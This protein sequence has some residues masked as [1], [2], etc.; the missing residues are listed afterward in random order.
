MAPLTAVQTYGMIASAIQLGFH[1][2]SG[3]LIRVFGSR[4]NPEASVALV[5]P[6]SPFSHV[7]FSACACFF[8]LWTCQLSI[9]GPSSFSCFATIA[10]LFPWHAPH[11]DAFNWH[12][13]QP[14]STLCHASFSN[15]HRWST[16]YIYLYS[17][18]FIHSCIHIIDRI[19][20]NQSNCINSRCF[21]IFLLFS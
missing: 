8:I 19:S 15:L 6:L 14:Y 2:G 10:I 12:L 9:S 1:W 7:R 5:S 13:S 18:N 11:C 17:L 20:N 4:C 3:P 21:A 16:L